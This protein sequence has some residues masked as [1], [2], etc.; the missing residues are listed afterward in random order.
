ML[1]DFDRNALGSAIGHNEVHVA[2]YTVAI[3]T[4]IL[5]DAL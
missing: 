3:A 1:R 5:R 4:I 2:A